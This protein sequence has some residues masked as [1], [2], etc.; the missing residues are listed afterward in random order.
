MKMKTAEQLG[1]AIRTRRKQ[2]KI[3]QKELAMTCG[4]GLRFIVDLEKGKPTCQIG[5]TLQVLQTLGLAIETTLLSGD[6]AG[7]KR[8]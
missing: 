8:P 3:T 5:K 6:D 4:T 2:L 7:G 1:K